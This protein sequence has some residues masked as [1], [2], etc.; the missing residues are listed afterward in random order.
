MSEAQTWDEILEPGEE[1]LWQGRPD[2]RLFFPPERKGTLV[3]GVL[4]MAFG[5]APLISGLRARPIAEWPPGMP[6]IFGSVFLSIVAVGLALV[7]GQPF[8]I[9]RRRRRT[10]YTLT[11]R[12]GFI[13]TDGA[14]FGKRLK[15][16]PVVSDAPVTVTKGQPATVWFARDQY[17][18]DGRTRFE[19]VGFE[20]IADADFVAEKIRA[21]RNGSG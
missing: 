11:N 2:T 4:I 12:R 9:R 13:A 7:V 1:I 3:A 19:P 10:W 20:R 16:Y 5:A 18:S 8:L 17:D 14:I 15:S 21:L 6:L